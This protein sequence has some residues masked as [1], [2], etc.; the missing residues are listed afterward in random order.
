VP[1]PLYKIAIIAILI[2]P[3]DL[4]DSLAQKLEQGVVRMSR[5]PRIFNLR[6]RSAENIKSLIDHSHE[7]KACVA[8][9]LCALKINA[10]RAVKFRPYG[11]CLFVTNYAHADFPPPDAFMT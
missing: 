9:D 2:A 5:R 10:D 1:G 7:K 11:P 3:C 6:Y 8:G 4:I